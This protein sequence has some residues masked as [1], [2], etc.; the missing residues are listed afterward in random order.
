MDC[1]CCSSGSQ[2][3]GRYLIVTLAFDSKAES[4]EVIAEI[5]RSG[6]YAGTIK[7][8]PFVPDA[9]AAAQ[10]AASDEGLIC[11]TGSIYLV[12]EVRTLYGLEAGQ[13][14]NVLREKISCLGMA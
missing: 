9:L 11:V 13:A 6:G 12:G 1:D 4:P 14:V 2:P 3:A 7:V 10:Q 5:A 8:I